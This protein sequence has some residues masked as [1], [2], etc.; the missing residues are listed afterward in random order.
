MQWIIVELVRNVLEPFMIA[1][2]LLEGEKYI[3]ISFVPGI[4]YSI[5]EGLKAVEND[6]NNHESVKVLSRKMLVDF[7]RRWESGDEM[8]VFSENETE[9]TQRTLK[10]LSKLTMMAAACDPRTK[11]LMGIPDTDKFLIL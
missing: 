4:I 8:T 1:Q 6:E 11:F 3:T 7:C 10:G 2:K 9:G 5:R